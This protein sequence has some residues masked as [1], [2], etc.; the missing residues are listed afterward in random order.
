[1]L[2]NPSS[3]CQVSEQCA[4]RKRP[5]SPLHYLGS[6]VKPCSPATRPLSL[7]PQVNGSGTVPPE[8]VGVRRA[9]PAEPPV[10]R[11]I[12]PEARRLIVNKNA[13]ETLLQRAAR[14]GYEEVVLYCLENRV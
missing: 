3:S 11:P 13:G 2:S 10:V 4:R 9:P 1:V 8:K 14:L 6:P 5:S 12:P 7:P